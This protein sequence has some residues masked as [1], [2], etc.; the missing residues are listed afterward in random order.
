MC[1]RSM[2][3]EGRSPAWESRVAEVPVSRLRARILP[4][5][6]LP[7]CRPWRGAPSDPTGGLQA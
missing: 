3:I 7:R 1:A 6:L 2:V 5:P 4:A